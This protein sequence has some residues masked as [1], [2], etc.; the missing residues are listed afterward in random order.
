MSSPNLN[1]LTADYLADKTGAAEAFAVNAGQAIWSRILD[2]G[3]PKAEALVLSL[4]CLTAI[5]QALKAGEHL[6]SGRPLGVWFRIQVRGLLVAYW[7]EES[8][9]GRPLDVALRLHQAVTATL[10]ELP[11]LQ[12]QMVMLR[13]DGSVG[14]Y[15]VLARGLGLPALVVRQAHEQGLATLH[16]QLASHPE[17]RPVLARLAAVA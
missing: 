8:L 6:S 3:F 5:M 1:Q 4:R 10:D 14:T 11:P 2:L 9:L 13:P 17:L 7:T 15:A 16:H 12:R